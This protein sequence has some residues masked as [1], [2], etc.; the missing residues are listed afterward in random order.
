MEYRGI[1]FFFQHN[2]ILWRVTNYSDHHHSGIA[3]LLYMFACLPACVYN[4]QTKVRITS[5]HCKTAAS[6]SSEQVN[7]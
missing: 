1:T 7:E 2:N 4:I 6:P 5:I 3:W